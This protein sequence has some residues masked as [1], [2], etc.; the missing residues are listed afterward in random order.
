MATT[1]QY[2]PHRLLHC[3]AEWLDN[4]H[5]DKTLFP[6]DGRIHWEFLNGISNGTHCYETPS[7]QIHEIN[8]YEKKNGEG[9]LIKAKVPYIS[10]FLPN[11]MFGE[12]I[13]G[14]RR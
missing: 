10:F 13:V 4:F 7:I 5:C 3:K 2:T 11:V 6:G 8:V 1:Y 12:S 14:T 9:K